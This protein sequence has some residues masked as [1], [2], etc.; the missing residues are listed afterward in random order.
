MN[1]M[2]WVCSAG[3]LCQRSASFGLTCYTPATEADGALK[4]GKNV[5]VLRFLVCSLPK[6]PREAKGRDTLRGTLSSEL[7][8]TRHKSSCRGI[9]RAEGP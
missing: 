4:E 8:C 7:S 2:H 6:V 9:S 1:P 5:A 3:Q